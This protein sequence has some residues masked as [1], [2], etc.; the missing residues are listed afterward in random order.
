MT[1]HRDPIIRHTV[2]FGT[3][4][5]VYKPEQIVALTTNPDIVRLE[6]FDRLGASLEIFKCSPFASTLPTANLFMPFQETRD[7]LFFQRIDFMQL[8]MFDL[9]DALTQADYQHIIDL[10]HNNVS[11]KELMIEFAKLAA[12]EFGSHSID[13]PDQVFAV[14]STFVDNMFKVPAV[15]LS[16]DVVKA[17]QP[18]ISVNAHGY[19]DTLLQGDILKLH[20]VIAAIMLP[21]DL[22]KR[23]VRELNKSVNQ[24]LADN[25][26]L[27][28][29]PRFTNKETDL[30]GLLPYKIPEN[31]MVFY[32]I[33][34]AA[35]A[36]QSS[37]FMLGQGKIGVGARQCPFRKFI[38]PFLQKLRFYIDGSI[39]TDPNDP[40]L[41]NRNIDPR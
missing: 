16:Y 18:D 15:P 13:T 37:L 29:S 28:I 17:V 6:Q 3:I 26:P 27:L 2:L 7:A 39:Q 23:T 8:K 12:N 9:L 30:G 41:F 10:V 19:I 24:I 34:S 4:V 20:N 33:K 31:S 1:E 5:A 40:N 22:I 14:D 38:I 35:K 11:D 32:A 36:A 21:A 25:S